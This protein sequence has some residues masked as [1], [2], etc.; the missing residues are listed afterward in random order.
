MERKKLILRG[1][2][3][4]GRQ[5][6]GL[7]PDLLLRIPTPDGVTDRLGE[8]KAM[9]AG[10]SRYP[11]GRAEKQADRRARE[12]PAS[13]RRPLERLDQR[14]GTAAG[15]T[16]PLVARLNGYG[17]L[18]CLVAGAWG[19]STHLHKLIVT[20]AESRVAHLC[21]STG[22]PELESQLGVITGQYRRL[23]SSC[24]VRAQAQCLISRIG[25]I[26]PE[27][28]VAA[29]RREVA[30]RLERQLQEERQAQW[31]ASLRGPGW[32]RRGRCHGF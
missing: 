32:A 9:S 30:G 28:R 14:R 5:R 27:A 24:I 7:T 2:L 25:V 16:G 19:D 10:I 29:Q 31:M 15:A 17:E 21:R 23:L 26:S 8:V 6:V 22:R 3:Q 4:Y 1:E 12:L 20:C 18:L 13:Y 11:S